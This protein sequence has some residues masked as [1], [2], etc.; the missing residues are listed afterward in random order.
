L[1]GVTGG[2]SGVAEITGYP[3]NYQIIV[4]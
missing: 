1:M 2:V 4:W 3:G